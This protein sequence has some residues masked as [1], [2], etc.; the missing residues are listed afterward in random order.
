LPPPRT[1]YEAGGVLLSNRGLYLPFLNVAG[2]ALAAAAIALLV[3][4]V[5]P[6]WIG[7]TRRLHLTP[8]ER[9]PFRFG[10]LGLAL[11]FMLIALM[12]GRLPDAA[13]I[14]MP[15][16]RGLNVRGGLRISPEFTALLVA[17]AIYGGA[18]IGE[19]V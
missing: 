8:D 15:E 17:M 16:L 18:Y 10:A 7:R 11:L 3:A 13:L 4:I 14:D 2:P 12:L 6:I 19:I 1:A 5:L 9:K